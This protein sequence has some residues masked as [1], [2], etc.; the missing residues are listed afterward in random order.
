LGEKISYL[1]LYNYCFI[2]EKHRRSIIEIKENLRDIETI[3]FENRAKLK[4]LL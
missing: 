4:N 1:S 2:V 3:S